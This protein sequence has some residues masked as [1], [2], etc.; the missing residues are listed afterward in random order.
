MNLNQRIMAD[1]R[2]VWFQHLHKA[3]GTYVIRRAMANG[4]TFWPQHKNGNPAKNDKMIPIWDYSSEELTE[5]IDHCQNNNI[6]FVACEWGTPDFATLASDPRVVLLT[7]LRQPINRLI[8]NFNYD[9]YWMWTKVDNY[10]D[11]IEQGLI[12]SSPE[13]YT[14]MF[15]GGDV[16]LQKAKENIA[17]FDIIIIAEQNMDLLNSLGWHKESDT[18]HPT[19]GDY[20]RAAILLVK[21]RFIRLINYIRKKK[22]VP[23][24]DL[25]IEEQNKLDLEFYR[26]LK[27]KIGD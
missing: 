22:F 21:L 7:C 26:E 15:S 12:H 9:Y 2:L 19:Y 1:Y 4:E 10:K 14:R 24:D 11:Y 8:S 27:N 6:T 16:D 13:Y 5:F 18:T 20:K 17:L 3:A 23:S 25:K